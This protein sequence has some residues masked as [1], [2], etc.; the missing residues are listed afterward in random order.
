MKIVIVNYGMGNLRSIQKKLGWNGKEAI[1]SDDLKT[2][3][4][5]DK[6]ILPGVGHFGNAVH[7]LQ[8]MNILDLLNYKA[9]E[10]KTPIL[11]I[12]LGMQLMAKNSEEGNE[13][14]F[15]WFDGKVVKFA[16]HNKLKYKVPHI[17][18][19]DILIKKENPL[20]KG[21]ETNKK[22][23]FVHSYHFVSHNQDEILTT[24]DY[25]YSFVSSIWKE[26]IFGV[27]FHP[28]KSHEQGDILLKNFYNL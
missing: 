14:G 24:T 22:F 20:F 10:Q 27:Q 1:V 6:L 25:E 3:E 5:A 21:I 18:W 13:T 7:R 12:C 15:G 4:K 8:S 9:I 28:E 26:N 17:G 23:Y 11:G 19:N 2:I 16:V